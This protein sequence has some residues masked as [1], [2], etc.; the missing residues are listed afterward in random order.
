ML[1]FSQD[2]ATSHKAG[3][4][5]DQ[6]RVQI[7]AKNGYDKANVQWFLDNRHT[8]NHIFRNAN[9]PFLSESLPYIPSFSS[10]AKWCQSFSYTDSKALMVIYIDLTT[11][12]V[13]LWNQI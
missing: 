12:S 10:S 4:R 3:Y 6:H 1:Q 8:V 2:F 13:F 9:L 5:Q 7:P 11:D